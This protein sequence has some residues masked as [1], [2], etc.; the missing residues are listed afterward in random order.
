MGGWS[1]GYVKNTVDFNLEAAP[2]P[3]E[4]RQSSMRALKASFPIG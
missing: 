2:L 4:K 3:Q 1:L